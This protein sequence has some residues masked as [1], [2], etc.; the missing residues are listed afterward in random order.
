LGHSDFV[1]ALRKFLQCRAHSV[2]A[3]AMPRYHNIRRG[4]AL[5]KT[6]HTLALHA[7]AGSQTQRLA[8]RRS[9]KDWV[10]QAAIERVRRKLAGADDGKS[11]DGRHPKR[12]S[13]R[14]LARSR[15]C[16][17]RGNRPGASI[18]PMLFSTSRPA[19]VIQRR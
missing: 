13:D 2:R 14:R 17:R 18:L 12:G 6:G 15:G 16:L 10:L 1:E 5:L 7:G 9:F 3:S 19:S 11:A 8:Q 4:M